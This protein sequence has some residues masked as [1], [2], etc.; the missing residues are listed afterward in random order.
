MDIDAPAD[1]MKYNQATQSLNYNYGAADGEPGGEEPDWQ[2]KTPVQYQNPNSAIKSLTLPEVLL[3]YNT[4]AFP[5]NG[6][7]DTFVGAT[8]RMDQVKKYMQK[9]GAEMDQVLAK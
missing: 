9:Q 4:D 7:V 3:E 8:L 5:D 1:D 6:A 2:V